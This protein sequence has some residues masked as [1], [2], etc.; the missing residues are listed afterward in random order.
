MY[1]SQ[2]HVFLVDFNFYIPLEKN[3]IKQML[4]TLPAHAEGFIRVDCENPVEMHDLIWCFLVRYRFEFIVM[5]KFKHLSD[6]FFGVL[7]SFSTK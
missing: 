6:T 4:C 2:H 5:Q 1:A 7:F 3:A